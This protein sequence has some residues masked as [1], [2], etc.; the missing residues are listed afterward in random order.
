MLASDREDGNTKVRRSRSLLEIARPPFSGSMKSIPPSPQSFD[1]PAKAGLFYFQLSM[2]LAANATDGN[3]NCDEGAAIEMIAG[4][5][6]RD[7]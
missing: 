2:L 6:F 1:G 7:R 4:Y 5:P 3:K